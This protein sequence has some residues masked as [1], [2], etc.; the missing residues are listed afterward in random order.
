[1]SPQVTI[2]QTIIDIAI[3]G[4]D[5]NCVP[6]EYNELM[7]PRFCWRSEEDH[8]KFLLVFASPKI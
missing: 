5:S 1:L 8:E 6:P 2:F 3:A 4:R 7:V